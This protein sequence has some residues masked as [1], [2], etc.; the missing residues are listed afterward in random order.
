MNNAYSINVSRTNIKKTLQLIF[1][2]KSSK[3]NKI[4]PANKT[5]IHSFRSRKENKCIGRV[6]K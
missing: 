3:I 1:S 6:S 4:V 2:D 5:A